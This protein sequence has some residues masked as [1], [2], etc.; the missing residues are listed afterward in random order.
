MRV[1]TY[2][3]IHQYHMCIY[4]YIRHLFIGSLLW[5]LAVLGIQHEILKL[6]LFLHHLALS[7]LLCLI[8]S[9]II[10]GINMHK[11]WRE[12]YVCFSISVLN[13]ELWDHFGT[14]ICTTFGS[15]CL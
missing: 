6:L 14:E 10:L 7:F 3:I 15:M 12:I 2:I 5:C 11:N 9:E 4:I 1:N 8:R 13:Y